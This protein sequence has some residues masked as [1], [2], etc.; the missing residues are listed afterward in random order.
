MSVFQSELTDNSQHA[1]NLRSQFPCLIRYV[2]S[3]K[4]PAED[5]FVYSLKEIQSGRTF[6]ILE[7]EVDTDGDIF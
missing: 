7:T 1:S 3:D 5:R 4:K 2:A 6:R